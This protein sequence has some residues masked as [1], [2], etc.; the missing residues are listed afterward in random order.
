MQWL[1]RWLGVAVTVVGMLGGCAS[2]PD[3]DHLAGGV[4]QNRVA[5]DSGWS[6]YNRGQDIV[7][8]LDAQKP[9]ATAEGDF[10]ARHLEVEEAIS[11]APL[12]IGNRV[13][14]LTDGPRTYDAMLRDIRAA[15]QFIHM[16]SY[17]FDD[18]EVGRTFADAFIA[19]RAEGVAVALM[20]DGVGT[21]GT[22][23]A[24]FKR[25]R[26]A[27][28]QVVVFNPVNPARAKVGWAPNN[29][30]HRKLLVVDGKVGFLGGINISAVYASAPSHGGSAGSAL[31]F[32][33]GSK[34]T[35]VKADGVK[36]GDAKP[37]DVKPDGSTPDAA[38]APWRDTHIR[39]EGPAVGEIERVMQE[40]W[41]EQHGPPLDPRE[42]YP[43]ATPSGPTAMRIVANRPGDK[44]GYT[45]YLT[46]ISAIKSAQRSIH[47]TMAYFVP[48][49]AFV[50]ALTDAAQRGVDVGMV[51]PGFSDSSLVWHAG[52]S[53]YMPLLDAGAH[54]YE[55]RDA[56]LHA[57]TA[58]IDGVWSTVGSSNMDWRSFA[59]N[60]ELNAVILGAEFGA[61]ME[62][63]FKRDVADATPIS[64]EEWAQRGFDER[65][66]ETFSRLFER[67]L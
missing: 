10:L 37:D 21:L 33:G 47:I 28:V 9:S 52:R 15:R 16:E 34:A 43:R 3:T 48:D 45:L 26:D 61:E 54:L 39:V 55:R 20:V 6:N 56:M 8:K 29:R 19:K 66:M 60:Y 38:T 35:A 1:A 42:F 4:S 36:P 17:I 31:S 12:M 30:D 18:D 27:G 25:M 65:F 23:D 57:K 22:P 50:Q 46:L 67:W 41:A 13:T 24:L 5:T 53:Y 7:R 51:L 59:L 49:P 14:L 2:V 64:K 44:D 63:L 62:A 11:G 40:G 32:S 58:V